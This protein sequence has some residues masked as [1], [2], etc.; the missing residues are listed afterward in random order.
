M[1]LE[2]MFGRISR[3]MIRRFPAP[4]ERAA[5]TNS[6]SRRLSTCPRRGLAMYGT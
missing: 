5:S 2:A 4:W 3:N 6:F 1:M